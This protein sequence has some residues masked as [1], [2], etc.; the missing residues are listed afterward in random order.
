MSD[1]LLLVL[2]DLHANHK[3]GLARP[4][5]TVFGEGPDG[6][7]TEEEIKLNAMQQFLYDA[8]RE[9][10]TWVYTLAAGRPIIVKINGDVTQGKKGPQA[11]NVTKL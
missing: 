11:S 1:K 10:L 3:L 8:F 4:G 2:S 9:D 7:E 6:E 5:T